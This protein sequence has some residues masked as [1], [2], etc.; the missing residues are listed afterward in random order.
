MKKSLHYELNNSQLYFN[1][2][3]I[4][5]LHNITILYSNSKQS[6]EQT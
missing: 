1:Q 6:Y 4:P 2:T 3:S 5:I